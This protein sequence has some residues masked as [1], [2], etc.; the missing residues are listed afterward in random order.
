MYVIAICGPLESAVNELAKKLRLKVETPITIL[1][2][3]SYRVTNS[4][5][6]EKLKKDIETKEGIIL[7][8]GHSLYIDDSLKKFLGE[9]LKIKLF[10]ETSPESCLANFLRRKLAEDVKKNIDEYNQTI[11]PFND[12]VN[13]TKKYADVVIPEKGNH[14]IILNLLHSSIL[15]QSAPEN[16]EQKKPTTSA[17]FSSNR[18]Y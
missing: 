13:L 11:K 17:F 10:L 4:I 7:L 9:S 2:E 1:D 6:Y 15:A 18:L 8:V 14:E 16:E 5:D 12:E 3:S